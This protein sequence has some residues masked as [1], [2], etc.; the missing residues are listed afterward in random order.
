MS[1]DLVKA[2]LMHYYGER[3][4]DFDADCLCCRAWVEYDGLL[5]KGVRLG[6]EAAAKAI[7]SNWPHDKRVLVPMIRALD[8][9]AIARSEP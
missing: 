9:A 2:A 4:E 6:L 5:E 3:C 8:A 1:D 7:Q